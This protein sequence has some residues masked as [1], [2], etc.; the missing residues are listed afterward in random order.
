VTK[1]RPHK[2]KCDICQNTSEFFIS[3]LKREYKRST[4]QHWVFCMD[5]YNGGAVDPWLANKAAT[6]PQ[7]KTP[8]HKKPKL[9]TDAWDEA[10]GLSSPKPTKENDPWP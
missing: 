7:K 10:V 8:P 6:A 4:R 1:K 2:N 3:V 9:S 5:C